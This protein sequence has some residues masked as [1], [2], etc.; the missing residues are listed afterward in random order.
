MLVLTSPE[1]LNNTGG[2][3]FGMTTGVVVYADPHKEPETVLLGGGDADRVTEIQ[4]LVGG[5][6]DAVRLSCHDDSGKYKDFV[7][8]GYV[9]DEGLLLN[10]P[11]NPMASMLFSR[12]IAGDVVLV[13]GTNPETHQYD[14]ETYSLPMDF[15]EY[16]IRGVYPQVQESLVFSQMLATAVQFAVVQ[17]AITKEEFD[18]VQSFMTERSSDTDG[19]PAAHIS[20]LPEEIKEI[21][22]KCVDNAVKFAEELGDQ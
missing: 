11:L 1:A 5:H 8:L 19:A 20:E 22:T 18:K 12:H 21:L 4:S 6:F 7:L 14:G 3:M 9:H 17:G 15:A 10:L 16:L 13:N 2:V